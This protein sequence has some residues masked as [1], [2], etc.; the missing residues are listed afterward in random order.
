M[1]K[2]AVALATLSLVVAAAA[3]EGAKPSYE[4]LQAKYYEAQRTIADLRLENQT[5]K[6]R[7]AGGAPTSG[8]GS[9][10]V[11][12]PTTGGPSPEQIAAARTRLAEMEKEILALDAQIKDL[13]RQIA[14]LEPK[15]RDPFK[16]SGGVRRS[17]ADIERDQAALRDQG[18]D[19][20]RRR[21]A[22]NTRHT[23]LQRKIIQVEAGGER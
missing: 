10:P 2:L 4:E 19:L 23:E 21:E 20:Q 1:K 8:G 14:A 5:L 6:E 11:A 16:Q 22:L 9:A 13:P 15:P 18:R 3:Q 17:A 12:Q 7:L